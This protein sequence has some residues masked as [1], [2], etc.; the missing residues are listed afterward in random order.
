MS[1][2][3]VSQP[4]VRLGA[5]VVT[6]NRLAQLQVT[7]ARLLAEPVDHVMVV[8][9]AGSDGTADWLATQL[10]PRLHVMI[11]PQNTGGAGGF[12]AG[13]AALCDRYDPD[14]CVLMD[15]DGRPM[16]GALTRFRTAVAGIDPDGIT[17]GVIA[18]VV[19]YPDGRLCDMNLPSRN[20]FWNLS[21]FLRKQHGRTRSGFHLTDAELAPGAPAQPVDVTSFV[22]YFVSRGA[23]K[24]GGLPDGGLFIYGDDVLYS[25]HLRRAGVGILV[26]PALRFEHDCTTMGPGFVYRP[27]WKIYYH[28]RNGVGIARAAA[29]PVLS[30][31]ALLWYITLYWRRSR[32]CLPQERVIY[33]QMMWAGLRD[34]LAGRRGRNDAVHAAGGSPQVMLG[35][36]SAS[37]S[38]PRRAVAKPGQ[39]G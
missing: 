17:P 36:A 29:G 19:S 12:E 30:V 14:W 20:P 32:H 8:E 31:A 34:G 13:L 23:I 11:M 24:R 25:L 4:V 27:L 37:V 35:A 15:D 28:C 39:E 2:P 5:V 10:D 16:P 33:R 26:I 1:P 3:V 7:L 21:L 6:Y 9:N 38:G 18:A 22:G